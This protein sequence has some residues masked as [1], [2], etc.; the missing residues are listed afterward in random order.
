M[1]KVLLSFLILTLLLAA[2]GW[3][4]YGGGEDY[5][6]LTTPALLAED[7]LE[8]VL[9]YPEPI[10]NLAVSAGGRLFF[11]VHPEAR[12]K[13]NRLLEFVDGASVPF[14]NVGSQLDL[15]DTVLGIAIDRQN[16][17]WTIDHGNHG[18]KTPRL[19][20]F[21]LDKNEIIRDQRLPSEIAPAGSFLQDLQVSAD[22]R[23]VIIADASIWRLQPALIVYDVQ[24]GTARRVLEGATSVA[25]EDYVIR[26]PGRDMRYLGG[27]LTLKA[28]VDGI[29]LGEDWLY[30][31]ALTGSGLYRIA[32]ADLR[33]A[34]ISDQ[35][36]ATR[37]ERV[38]AKPLSDGMS[39][40][41]N[42]NVYITDI[43]HNAIFAV[44]SA[45]EVSTLIRSSRMRWP[46]ALSFGPDGWLYVADSALPDVVLQP[47]AHIQSQKP[48]RI[49][50]F[51][52]GTEGTPGQ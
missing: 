32:L 47:R 9:S 8:E 39:I 33:N 6:D 15:F 46:D 49:F 52:P 13:G 31:G 26:T 24:T 44:S 40:D 41:L 11:T 10:G 34:S 23:T 36:L 28:G 5:P 17:L 27:I 48:Y 14:P 50:R 19:L 42:G 1:K 51:R 35:Q 37:V 25:S 29:A 21:D 43:E 30:F 18:L 38:A 2:V 4:R 16:R 22:G 20:A 7:V 12:P 3:L 45:H